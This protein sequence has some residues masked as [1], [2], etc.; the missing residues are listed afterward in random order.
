MSTM[1]SAT[2]D[3]VEQATRLVADVRRRCVE[4]GLSPRQFA[5]VLLPEV[6]LAFMVSGMQQEDVEA[7]FAT[8]A[9]DEVPAWFLRV[10]R[11]VGYCDCAREAM[12]DHAAGCASL[13]QGLPE[14]KRAQTA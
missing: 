4:L 2:D 10:K 8:F 6:L 9:R 3:V 14:P 7:A 1:T 5:E 13:V 11:N 12:A